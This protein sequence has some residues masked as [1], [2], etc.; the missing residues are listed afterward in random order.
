[1]PEMPATIQVGPF[2]YAVVM[3]PAAIRSI[4]GEGAPAPASGPS[5]EQPAK[6]RGR[7]PEGAARSVSV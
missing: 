2:V 3:D 1:M 4:T 7:R 6:R 5:G